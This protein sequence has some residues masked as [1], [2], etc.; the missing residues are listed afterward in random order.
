MSVAFNVSELE[1]ENRVLRERVDLLERKVAFLLERLSITYVD[2][3]SSNTEFEEVIRLVNQGNKLEAIKVYRDKTGAS[4]R[5]A[6]QF[7]ERL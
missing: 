6:K 1:K 3:N 2:P 5:E 4:L 7:V